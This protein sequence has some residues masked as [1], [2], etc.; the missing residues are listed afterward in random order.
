M[1]R[2]LLEEVRAGILSE[3]QAGSLLEDALEM[4]EIGNVPRSLG[5]S[6]SEWMAYSHGVTPGELA[7][8]RHEGWPTACLQCEETIDP[9]RAGWVARDTGQGHRLAHVRCP[10]R[11]NRVE[12]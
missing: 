1:K 10:T 8:W 6:R 12:E 2:D 11:R 5:F 9:A 4:V 3:D 7:R